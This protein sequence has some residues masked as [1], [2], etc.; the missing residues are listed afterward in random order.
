IYT[1]G[2]VSNHRALPTQKKLASSAKVFLVVVYV[3]QTSAIK[4][5]FPPDIPTRLRRPL[6][7]TL[8][9]DRLALLEKPYGLGCPQALASH[10]DAGCVKK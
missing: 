3:N 6:A 4:P 7:Q 9:L 1:N 10:L 8:H 2:D 5:A